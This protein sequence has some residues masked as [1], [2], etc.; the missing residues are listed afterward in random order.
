MT[1]HS[2]DRQRIA[3]CRDDAA[4]DGPLTHRDEGE[5]STN[6]RRIP[7]IV[8]ERATHDDGNLPSLLPAAVEW[9]R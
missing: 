7:P 2:M 5:S 8:N 1:Q 3:I 6:A 9:A 4:R